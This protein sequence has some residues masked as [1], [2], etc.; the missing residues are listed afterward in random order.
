MAHSH[1]LEGI[2]ACGQPR[3][4]GGEA[5]QQVGQPNVLGAQVRASLIG[6]DRGR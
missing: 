4:D 1:L 5:A 3:H 2:Q 6:A